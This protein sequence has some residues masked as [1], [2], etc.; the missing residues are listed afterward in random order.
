MKYRMMKALSYFNRIKNSFNN[1]DIPD[2]SGKYNSID[3]KLIR[4]Y[5]QFRPSG[6]RKLLCYVPFNNMSFSIEG[7]V[8]ACNYNFKVLMG[9]YPE[10]S[11]KEIW[12]SDSATELRKHM[13]HN[14][15]SY[16]CEYCSNFLLNHKFSGLKPQ[17]YDKYSSYKKNQFPRVIEF[18]LLNTCNL[19]CVM[20]SGLASSSI[21]KNREKLPPI[22][23]PYDSE[24]VR[25]LE[26]FIPHLKEAKFYGGEPFL[27]EVY[28]QI[29]DRILDINP[30]INIFTITNGTVLNDR[31]KD[32]LKRGNFDLALSLDSVNKEK[33][34]S[35]RKNSDFE[36]VMQNLDYFNDYCRSRN[37]AMSFSTTLMRLNWEDVPGM[38]DFANKKGA[39]TFFSYLT[40][41]E[42]LGLY[43]LEPEELHDIREELSHYDFPEDTMLQKYNKYCFTD[44]LK[45]L[46]IW[47]DS[48]IQQREE[49]KKPPGKVTGN[50]NKPCVQEEPVIPG[51]EELCYIVNETASG[52]EDVFRYSL[53]QYI[54]MHYKLQGK[55]LEQKTR[56]LLHKFDRV[57]AYMENDFSKEDIYAYILKT[58]LKNI[59]HDL[60]K[61]PADMLGKYVKRCLEEY[62]LTVKKGTPNQ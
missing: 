59:I 15:L 41:P 29:W 55:E 44:F 22:N 4:E 16:G 42:H 1:W 7:R 27:I 50:E 26:E 23:N 8:L 58:P 62:L 14:D 49:Q 25:Q 36:T 9:K 61:E 53:N 60:E 38:I 5:N 30:S 54:A 21:R 57:M 19:E 12:F 11:L 20:C 3:P 6:P 13:E 17:V 37:K 46:K 40:R 34:L 45:Q 51:K 33:Y 48:N 28:H 2:I 47:E 39:Q 35:I 24:F 52:P 10:K 32:L 18:E 43:N 31:I 56:E